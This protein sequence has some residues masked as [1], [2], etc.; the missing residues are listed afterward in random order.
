MTTNE[1]TQSALKL[2]TVHGFTVWRT[3][4]GMASYRGSVVRLAPVGTPDI[5][6]Y[7]PG[8]RFVGIEVKTGRDQ[9]REAQK[10]W[11]EKAADGGAFV[12]EVHELDDVQ[13]A[14]ERYRR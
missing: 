8:G 1:L 5:I 13:R 14:I 9:L 3:N 7:G 6:G 11:R 12:A 10:A 4:A 2:L